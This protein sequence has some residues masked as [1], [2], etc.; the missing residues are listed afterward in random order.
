MCRSTP[1]AV[2]EAFVAVRTRS[3]SSKS[4]PF[5]SQTMCLITLIVSGLAPA[6]APPLSSDQDS[7]R[8]RQPSHLYAVEP[9]RLYSRQLA[10]R[11]V[12]LAAAGVAYRHRHAIRLEGTDKRVLVFSAGRGPLRARRG[13]ERDEVHMREL[14]AQPLAQ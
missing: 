4:V 1:I 12:D 3:W 7:G 11:A 10:A 9:L 8:C 13:V 2:S 14:A 6:R 5:Q